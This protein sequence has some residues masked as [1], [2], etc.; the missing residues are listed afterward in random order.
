MARRLTKKQHER[1]SNKKVEQID[2]LK[3]FDPDS[4]FKGRVIA[5]HGPHLMVED[6]EHQIYKA[7]AVL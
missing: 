6:A 5:Q 3:N 2:A 7:K 1:I 4:L